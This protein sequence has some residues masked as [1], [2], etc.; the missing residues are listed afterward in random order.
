MKALTISEP[1]ASMIASG[2]KWVEN[3]VWRAPPSYRGEL[4]I[5]AGKGTQYLDRSELR[6]YPT[7]CIV[8]VA[9]LLTALPLDVAHY[10]A[11]QGRVPSAWFGN[12]LSRHRFAEFLDHEH[13]E[14]PIC[15]VLGNVRRLKD[16]VSCQGARGLW[17]VPEWL[18]RAIR[19]AIA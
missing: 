19:E 14:G 2:E 4:A 9:D 12:G 13:T 15:L 3:R 18:E 6:G 11:R 7:Q 17:N 8:A 1:Y 5:H 16:P 10:H